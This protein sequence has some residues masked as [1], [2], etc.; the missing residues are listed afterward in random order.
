MLAPPPPHPQNILNDPLKKKEEVQQKNT[1]REQKVDAIDYKFEIVLKGNR[2]NF[3]LLYK[4]YIG[5]GTFGKVYSIDAQNAFK[6]DYKCVIKITKSYNMKD[7]EYD[8]EVHFYEL[9]KAKNYHCLP[10]FVACGKAY[11]TSK[12]IYYDYIILEYVGKNNLQHTMNSMIRNRF[13]TNNNMLIINILYTCLMQELMAL[14]DCEFVIRD[15]ALSNIVVSDVFSSVL[16]RQNI[17]MQ[18]ICDKFKQKKYQEI[19]KFVDLGMAGDLKE[20]FEMKKYKRNNLLLLGDFN[21]FENLDG[22]FAG[23]KM[24]ISPFSKLDL[25]SIIGK[26]YIDEDDKTVEEFEAIQYMKKNIIENTLIMNDIWNLCINFVKIIYEIE[27]NPYNYLDVIEQKYKKNHLSFYIEGNRVKIIGE[28]LNTLSLKQNEETLNKLKNT[29]CET[30]NI[31]INF[32]NN[33]LAKA[34]LRSSGIYQLIL[35]ETSI[36]NFYKNS[37]EY[38]NWIYQEIETFSKFTLEKATINNT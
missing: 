28:I 22:I 36:K 6:I 35:D 27:N 31:I 12:K 5:E 13:I 7:N 11:E 21:G 29:I 3:N 18:F 20:I 23:R 2:Y 15:I 14:H 19:V 17:D 9:C 30:L 37:K 25:S 38:L 4:D 26:K 10:Y 8:N 24:S 1:Q 16:N 33:M 32:A 34:S